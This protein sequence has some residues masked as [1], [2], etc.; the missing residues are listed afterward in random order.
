MFEIDLTYEDDLE[1]HFLVDLHELLIPLINI[2]GLLAVV[3][4]VL[5]SR[6]R[7]VA[8]VLA[9]L[10]DLAQYW[11]GDLEQTDLG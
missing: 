9:P 8:V 2:G 6:G 3:G 5:V 11:L 4:F 1:Q 10:D 7:I